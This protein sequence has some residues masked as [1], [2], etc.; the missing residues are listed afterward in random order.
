MKNKKLSL[1][2]CVYR[3]MRGGSYWT[4]WELRDAIGSVTGQ[5]FGEP[6]ISAA[7]R[8]MRKDYAR[9]QFELPKFGE[10]IEKKRRVD[11]KGY[12]Y[13]LNIGEKNGR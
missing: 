2:E 12:K 5:W 7:I 1:D 4:F 11:G 13:K 6:S 9:E 10:V 8:N 3:F